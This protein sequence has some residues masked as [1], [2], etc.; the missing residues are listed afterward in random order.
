MHAALSGEADV[1][2]RA[3]RQRPELAEAV[4]VAL[5]IGELAPV[6][7]ALRDPEWVNRV[8]IHGHKPFELPVFSACLRTHRAPA[9]RRVIALLLDHGASLPGAGLL[10]F[11]VD[12]I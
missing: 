4:E 5:V 12:D 2:E 6:Q 7:R 9:L 1:V 10:T 11:S 8:L 3:L